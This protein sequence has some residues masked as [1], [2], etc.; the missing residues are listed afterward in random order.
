MKKYYKLIMDGYDK[1]AGM[2]FGPESRDFPLAN[3]AQEVPDWQD[4]VLELRDGEY[5]P[6]HFCVKGANVVDDAFKELIESF[7]GEV[8]YL[9]FL[10]IKAVSPIYGEKRYYIMH[11]KKIFDV[12]D[13]KHSAYIPG[14][15]NL[16]KLAV[17][18]KK[19]DGLHIFNSDSYSRAI[20]VSEQLFKAIKKNKLY[21]GLDHVVVPCYID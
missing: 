5:C 19:V 8:D 12:I 1:V 6:L 16:V 3:D 21:M 17:D 7:I 11:F 10:P 9:E 4:I 20:I 13:K 2:L 15:K 14:T 18:P